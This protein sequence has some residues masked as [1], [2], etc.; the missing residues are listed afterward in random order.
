MQTQLIVNL[1]GSPPAHVIAELFGLIEGHQCHSLDSR[2][3]NLDATLNALLRLQGNWDRIT[4]L[5]TSLHDFANRH[6]LA[7]N[8]E[9]NQVMATEDRHL[10]YIIDAIGLV[11]SGVTGVLTQFCHNQG[12]GVREMNSH[13]YQPPHST[14]QLVQLRA[15]IKIPADLHLGRL[16]GEFFDLCD[17][18]NLDA[19]IEPDRTA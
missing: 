6:R 13:V 1:F 4:R 7:L 16:K 12:I 19:A 11:S 15:W 3:T 17:N 18:L 9:H 2:I 14:E 10:P 5:E 8:I